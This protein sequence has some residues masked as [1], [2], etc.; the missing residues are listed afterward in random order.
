MKDVERMKEVSLI[1]GT[2]NSFQVLGNQEVKSH[3]KAI[4]I[5]QICV[6]KSVTKIPL[7]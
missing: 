6:H 7:A 1:N 4:S 5:L 3:S 2:P